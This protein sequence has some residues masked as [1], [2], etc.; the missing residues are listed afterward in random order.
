MLVIRGPISDTVRSC[1]DRVSSRYGISRAIVAFGGRAPSK[2]MLPPNTATRPK[3]AALSQRPNAL[4]R[5]GATQSCQ[6]ALGG[7]RFSKDCDVIAMVTAG[8]RQQSLRS[9]TALRRTSAL[10]WRWADEP[11]LCFDGERRRTP[12]PVLSASTCSASH[13]A[14][15]EPAS[16]RLAAP[17]ARSGISSGQRSGSNRRRAGNGSPPGRR[18]VDT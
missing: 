18:I 12:E 16:S 14:R 13:H 4:Q 17:G 11:I 10:L 5:R 2:R 3:N 15:Q 9:A 7:W 8:L 1:R 6:R